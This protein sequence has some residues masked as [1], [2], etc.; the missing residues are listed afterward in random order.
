MLPDIWEVILAMLL[1]MVDTGTL[2]GKVAAETPVC[3]I[4]TLWEIWAE[5][6]NWH[7][8]LSARSVDPPTSKCFRENCAVCKNR[9]EREPAL[10]QVKGFV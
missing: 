7:Y 8:T 1:Y 3:I 2:E 4:G 10:C 9:T 5:Y 6:G